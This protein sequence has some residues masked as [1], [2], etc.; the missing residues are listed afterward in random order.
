MNRRPEKTPAVSKK[1]T[2]LFAQLAIA[3]AI[4]LLPSVAMAQSLANELKAA[5]EKRA[6]EQT[7]AG[8]I[9]VNPAPEYPEDKAAKAFGNPP[10]ARRLSMASRVWVDAKKK[11]VYVDGYVTMKRG[12]LEMF[13]CP[14]GSKEHESIVAVLAKSIEVHTA[15]L[16]VGT[17]TG[18]PVKFRPRFVP[19]T[20]QQVRI[21]VCWRDEDG[22]F[23]VT[24]SK[25]WIRKEGT[26]QD[27]KEDFVFAGSSFWTDP[28]D[29]REY[30]Q[31]D[32]GDLVCVSNFATAMIDVPM[33]SSASADQ[34]SF[35]PF[36]D[37][38]PERGTP[39]RLVFVP[40]P[41]PTDKPNVKLTYD[42]KLVPADDML[43]AFKP[44]TDKQQTKSK[45]ASPKTASPKTTDTPTRP[46]PTKTQ[47][48]I[49]Q[50]EK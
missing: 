42:P 15:L 23:Q 34:L 16:S 37:R 4:V 41:L 46:E 33:N 21:W 18:T 32:G 44:E 40:I 36:T 10:A 9:P 25:K 22:E 1:T 49:Q 43:P 31:A 5:D 26:K 24:D 39:V 12:P 35:T 48:D 19:P 30:Y 47:D 7:Q 2:Q 3:G 38:I 28:E 29:G 27:L 20:G 14:V 17:Q 8:D 6:A 13:A 45:T 11:R 50:T